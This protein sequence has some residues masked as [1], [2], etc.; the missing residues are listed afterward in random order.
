L[1]TIKHY[2]L[3][4]DSGANMRRCKGKSRCAG[5]HP[6][7]SRSKKIVKRSKKEKRTTEHTH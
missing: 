1:L 7:R 6:C 2:C 4:K 5:A 3:E